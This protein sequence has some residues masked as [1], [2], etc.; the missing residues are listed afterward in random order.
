MRN[1]IKKNNYHNLKNY[2]LDK[3]CVILACGPSLSSV[4]IKDLKSRIKDKVVICI[5]QSILLF[6]NEC[7]L[8]FNNF[9]NYQEY[10]LRD[11]ILSCL[12]LWDQNQKIHKNAFERADI[13][14]KVNPTKT[15]SNIS[16]IINDDGFSNLFCLDGS[17]NV[18]KGPGIMYEAVLPLVLY[19]GFKKITTFGW[20]IG[21]NKNSNQHFYN[22]NNEITS[23]IKY[24]AGCYGGETDLIL[25]AIPKI[26]NLFSKNGVNITV[27]S[28]TNPIQQNKVFNRV[29]YEQWC[30]NEA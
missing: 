26:T 23:K 28:D 6:D 7:D 25:S 11:Q 18:L 9:C 1:L 30:L 29:T 5:K 22:K 19:M 10:N 3:E 20:D 14:F 15:I 13:C 17:L 8:H 16:S 27:I 21:D 4:D 2:F 24:R 12:I